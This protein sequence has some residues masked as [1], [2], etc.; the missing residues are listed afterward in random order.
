MLS[1]VSY[2]KD[3]DT[4]IGPC[5]SGH[6]TLR[7]KLTTAMMKKMQRACTDRPVHGDLRTTKGF[8]L[9]ATTNNGRHK[10]R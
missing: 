1:D 4:R 9:S 7:A 5:Y 6:K 3:K 10:Y 2:R 8:K